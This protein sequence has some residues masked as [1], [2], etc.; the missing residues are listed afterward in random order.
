MDFT[1]SFHKDAMFVLTGGS[2]VQLKIRETEVP[3]GTCE[4]SEHLLPVPSAS[5]QLHGSD[6]GICSSV[7]PRFETQLKDG[8]IA[9]TAMG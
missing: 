4:P 6:A 7:D 3:L 2:S 1:G 5:S 8:A 9:A